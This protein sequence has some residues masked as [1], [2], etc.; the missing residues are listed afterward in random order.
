MSSAVVGQGR[1]HKGGLLGKPK[2]WKEMLLVTQKAELFLLLM[3]E[4][5]HTDTSFHNYLLVACSSC[6]LTTGVI[7]CCLHT[8][9]REAGIHSRSSGI[10]LMSDKHGCVCC[11]DEMRSAQ[12]VRE[13]WECADVV[14]M[15]Q[16]MGSIRCAAVLLAHGGLLAHK[17]PGRCVTNGLA[18][19]CWGEMFG[20]WA[21]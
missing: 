17:H 4:L 12:R 19:D 2:G 3:L 21:G 13:S 16:A 7:M 1:T 15:R 14:T 5:S 18:W 8:P 20:V 6:F 9:P 10:T 11:W